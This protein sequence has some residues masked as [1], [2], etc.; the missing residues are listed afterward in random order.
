M[1]TI[2][3][4]RGFSPCVLCSVRMAVSGSPIRTM[5]DAAALPAMVPDDS[6]APLSL[7]RREPR[8]SA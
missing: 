7:P 1:L 8:R 5:G 3:N 2:T 4:L 6:A